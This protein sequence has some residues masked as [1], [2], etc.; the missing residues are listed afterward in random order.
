MLIFDAGLLI[1]CM[2]MI[3]GVYMYMAISI[4]DEMDEECDNC[5]HYIPFTYHCRL[6]NRTMLGANYCEDWESE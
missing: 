1:L 2:I 4:G 5:K 3:V 6:H